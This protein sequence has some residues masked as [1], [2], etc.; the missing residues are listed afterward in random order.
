MVA[1]IQID[2]DEDVLVRFREDLLRRLHGTGSRGVILDVSAL[3][4]LDSAE[5]SA[6][7]DIIKMSEIMGAEAVLVGL[8]PGVVSS[9]IQAGV[10]VEGVRSTINLDAAHALLRSLL[11]PELELTA[12]PNPDNEAD[13]DVA[14]FLS[15]ET[16]GP[17][18]KQ[19]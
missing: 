1:S 4:I 7:R 9:L 10:E 14:H 6:L 15:L 8:Q 12:D 3:D 17:R 16:G 11:V 2:L 18:G 13:A 19:P 5:F